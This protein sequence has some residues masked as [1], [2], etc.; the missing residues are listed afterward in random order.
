MIGTMSVLYLVGFIVAG[1]LFAAGVMLLVTEVRLRH[2]RPPLGERLTPFRDT[3]V[4]D[5][6]EQWLR[7]Q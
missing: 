7:N 3:T 1:V 2:R 6:A 5:E 4:A